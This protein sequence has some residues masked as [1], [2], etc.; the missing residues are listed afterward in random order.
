MDEGA[1]ALEADLE[2]DRGDGLAGGKTAQGLQHPQLA[3]RG[4]FQPNPND[5]D[6]M[7]PTAAFSMTDGGPA[8]TAAPPSLGQDS[9][10][11]L[12]ALGYDAAR[13][14]GLFDSGVVQ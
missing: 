14:A 13:I 4:Y 3:A 8:L 10:E 1:G 12:V 2:G 7:L 6:S 11:T 9:H 5:P